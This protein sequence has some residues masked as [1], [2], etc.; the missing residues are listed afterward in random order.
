MLKL[1]K[2]VEYG[3]IALLDMDERREGDPT[4]TK[5]I[6]QRYNLPAE[7]LGKVLQKLARDGLI[8]SVHG[9]HGGYRVVKLLEALTLGMIFESIEGPVYLADCQDDP[10]SCDQYCTC[11][12]REPVVRIQEQLTKFIHGVKL[13][14]FRRSAHVHDE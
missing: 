7:L 4:T 8:E 12:I 11:N 9:A 5:D 14:T 13:S 1:S 2:K 6:A 10:D 3:L